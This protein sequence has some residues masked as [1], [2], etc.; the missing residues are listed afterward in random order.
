M[1]VNCQLAL[2]EPCVTLQV[3]F[4]SGVGKGGI[5]SL[6]GKI[7]R[8]D[9][10]VRGQST[11]KWTVFRWWPNLISSC[12]REQ[13]SGLE[14]RTDFWISSGVSIGPKILVWKRNVQ[15]MVQEALMDREASGSL[16]PGSEKKTLQ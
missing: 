6:N 14:H 16:V 1:N 2:H 3:L 15:N 12:P 8:Q 11:A 9:L 7:Q 5:E 10:K 13:A 4:Q